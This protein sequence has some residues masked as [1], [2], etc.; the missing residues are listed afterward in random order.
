MPIVKYIIQTHFIDCEIK[1]FEY[2]R[3]T[4]DFLFLRGGMKTKKNT[5]THEHLDTW[6]EAKDK[7]IEIQSGRVAR[8]HAQYNI[9]RKKLTKIMEIKDETNSE[10]CTKR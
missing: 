1:R 3:E 10:E 5:T 6:Q 9:E 7:L 4:K 8:L 2:D